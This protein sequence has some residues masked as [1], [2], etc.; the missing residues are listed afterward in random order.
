MR[1]SL[2][3]PSRFE[4]TVSKDKRRPEQRRQRLVSKYKSAKY[5]PATIRAPKA[6]I[7]ASRATGSFSA[8]AGVRPE[9]K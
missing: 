6:N 2:W 4:K 8:P 5:P 9:S 7:P 3:S 1:D